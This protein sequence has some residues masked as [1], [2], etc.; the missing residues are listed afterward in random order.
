MTNLRRVLDWTT[1]ILC[2][3]A[4]AIAIRIVSNGMPTVQAGPAQALPS[5]YASESQVPIGDDTM[6]AGRLRL[7]A[8]GVPVTITVFA[9]F[10]CS[11][12]ADLDPVLRDL[13]TRYP[14]QVAIVIKHFVP[15]AIRAQLTAD[16]AAECAA[17]QGKFPEFDRAFF[18][19]GAKSGLPDEWRRIGVDIGIHD[20]AQYDRCVR[21]Q[22]HL[23]AVVRDTREAARLGVDRTPIE[24]VNGRRIVGVQAE[25]VYDTVIAAALDRVGR[26]AT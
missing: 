22:R 14:D 12:C 1:V 4:G 6:L 21:S 2:V 8:D 7:G 19:Y 26:N 16:L 18:A 10:Y 11:H 25:A 9:N 24:F 17:D 20:L 13:V 3:A 23:A 5:A 15:I